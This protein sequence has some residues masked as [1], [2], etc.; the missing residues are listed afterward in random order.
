MSW[1]FWKQ[2]KPCEKKNKKIPLYF[3][4]QA[5]FFSLF[6]FDVECH[7]PICFLHLLCDLDHI[8]SYLNRQTLTVVPFLVRTCGT[9]RKK[10]HVTY[11]HS[12]YEP[13]F[14]ANNY[15][16]DFFAKLFSCW[17]Y[18]LPVWNWMADTQNLLNYGTRDNSH[19]WKQ[20]LFLLFLTR[21]KTRTYGQLQ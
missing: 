10:W 9:I 7:F 11:L 5:S 6:V 21:I 17:N 3:I 18:L 16:N 14:R 12:E 1:K 19:A 4:S 8:C 2:S 15:E 13:T 20:R